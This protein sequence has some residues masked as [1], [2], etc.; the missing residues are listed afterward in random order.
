MLVRIPSGQ[1]YALQ[2]EKEQ[3]WLPLLAPQLPLPIPRPVA[4]GRPT[5]GFPLP[6]SVYSWLEGMPATSA[7][8]ADLAGFA[9]DLASFLTALYAID[10][11][12]GPPPGPHSF[13]RGAS[14]TV[15]EREARQAIDVLADLIDATAAGDLL[16]RAVVTFWSRAPVW[17]HGDVAA[18]NLLV[19]DGRLAGVIDFGCSAVGDPACDLAIAWTLL[20]GHS[21]E[22]FRR[23]VSLDADTWVRGRGWALWKAAITMARWH[24]RDAERTAHAKRVIDEL[25]TGHD[26]LA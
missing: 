22:T 2:V 19:V 5:Q 24:D 3:R 10:P 21:R 1:Q 9:L 16:D 6:W 26:A 23:A 7:P 20:E 25:L 15:Y 13:E 18:D 4:C 14:L 17:V 8:I 11:A 12:G